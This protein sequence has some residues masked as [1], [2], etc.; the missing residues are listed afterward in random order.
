MISSPR[1]EIL[2]LTI[3]FVPELR[4]L[5][6]Y[7][8]RRALLRLGGMFRFYHCQSYK[9]EVRLTDLPGP[10]RLYQLGFSRAGK[11][12]QGTGIFHSPFLE[13]SI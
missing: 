2:V 7:S 11:C 5:L 12:L 13:Y 6:F 1:L 8:L 9:V 3:V 4:Y 10:A